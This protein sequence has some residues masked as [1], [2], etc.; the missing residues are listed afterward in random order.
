MSHKLY[1]RLRELTQ[2]TAYSTNPYTQLTYPYC[3]DVWSPCLTFVL[4]SLVGMVWMASLEDSVWPTC[5]FYPSMLRA[6]VDQWRQISAHRLHKI[7][8]SG[9]SRG[10]ACKDQ[11]RTTLYTVS[12]REQVKKRAAAC[13]EKSRTQP[14]TVEP[15]PQKHSIPLNNTPYRLRCVENSLFGRLCSDKVKANRYVLA[16]PDW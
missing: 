3:M 14:P 12:C 7:T 5:Y 13:P 8:S 11:R 1:R 6:G 10:T 15:D 2:H 9:S 4:W 16:Y